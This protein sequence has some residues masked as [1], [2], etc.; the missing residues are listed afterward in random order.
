MGFF[1]S[2][3]GVDFFLEM[4]YLRDCNNFL[5]PSSFLEFIPEAGWDAFG[6]NP[7]LWS[8]MFEDVIV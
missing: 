4:F 1:H 3:E 7:L 2:G 8:A 5:M 6:K